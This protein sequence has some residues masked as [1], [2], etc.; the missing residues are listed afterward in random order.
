MPPPSLQGQF[1]LA[2]ADAEW[3]VQLIK[4]RR[5]DPAVRFESMT[6]L[7]P[8]DG[9]HQGA[10]IKLRLSG[11]PFPRKDLPPAIVGVSNE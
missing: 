2:N 8:F 6:G 9:S 1:Q 5:V 3:C 4:R 11:N 7:K 10:F